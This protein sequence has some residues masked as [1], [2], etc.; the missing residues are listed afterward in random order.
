MPSAGTKYSS[1]RVLT[2]QGRKDKKFSS[3]SF[4][5]YLLPPSCNMDLH[6]TDEVRCFS[7]C[8]I[9][10]KVAG[11]YPNGNAH[12]KVAAAFEPKKSPKCSV[13]HLY[14]LFVFLLMTAHTIMNFVWIY[15]LGIKDDSF[16]IHSKIYTHIRDIQLLCIII[17]FH[18]TSS[19]ICPFL[20]EWHKIRKQFELQHEP[21]LKRQAKR[22]VALC[23][24]L[25]LSI[26]MLKSYI[27]FVGDQFQRATS[28]ASLSPTLSVVIKVYE[29]VAGVYITMI[30]I[31]FALFS[32]LTCKS[33]K[34][35][36]TFVVSK[37]W[38]IFTQFKSVFVWSQQ[39]TCWEMNFAACT[40]IWVVLLLSAMA[41]PTWRCLLSHSEK[42]IKLCAGAKRFSQSFRT[43][44]EKHCHSVMNCLSF[45][46]GSV[47]WCIAVFTSRKCLS[48]MFGHALPETLQ[49][50][51]ACEQMGQWLFSFCSV[52]IGDN[53]NCV[54]C[55]VVINSLHQLCSMS[56]HCSLINCF[57]AA[58]SVQEIQCVCPLSEF[59]EKIKRVLVFDFS[60]PGSCSIWD[61]SQPKS[62][63]LCWPGRSY[64]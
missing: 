56:H 29:F 37:S 45:Q 36:T 7:P 21:K 1:R 40:L 11:L 13:S 32:V 18:A 51:M 33:C 10:L 24:I 3:I 59:E 62:H 4:S 9:L 44:S 27:I 41:K 58:S 50:Y 49:F 46:I 20:A 61:P 8:L 35:S 39:V 57:N 19:T 30:T 6:D 5:L 31:S 17:F 22:G 38:K 60:T 47:G 28:L 16:D 15:F 25:G 34:T 12:G 2:W 64:Q 53:V 42:D 52:W 55:N 26:I 48:L 63:Q 14:C 23:C 43:W 54:V